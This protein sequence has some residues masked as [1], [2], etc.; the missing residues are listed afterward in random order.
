[1]TVVPRTLINLAADSHYCYDYGYS[2]TTALTL[3]SLMTAMDTDYLSASIIVMVML[4]T[5]NV[6]L[7]PTS[8]QVPPFKESDYNTYHLF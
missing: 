7:S 5:Q 6:S 1:M 2:V 3:I 4:T 8:A